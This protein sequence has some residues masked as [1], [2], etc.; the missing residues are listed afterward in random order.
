MH[1][2][3]QAYTHV[4]TH[5]HTH[6]HFWHPHSSLQSSMYSLSLSYSDP[7]VDPKNLPTGDWLCRR[8]HPLP[9]PSKPPHPFGPLLEQACMA[10]PLE[11]CLPVEMQ[12]YGVFPGGFGYQ[13]TK[14]SAECVGI[15]S[16]G[17]VCVCVCVCVCDVVRCGKCH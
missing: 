6:T 14:D 15:C 8:C 7:P 13:T 4:H 10:N 3:T 17:C 16:T 1:I 11:F 5:T 9:I 2:Y 12:K